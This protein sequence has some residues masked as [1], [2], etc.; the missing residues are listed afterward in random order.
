[1]KRLFIAIE[2]PQQLI[3][4]LEKELEEIKKGLK[5]LSIKWVKP[6]NFHITLAF[7]GYKEEEKIKEISEIVKNCCYFPQ[8]E[9]L[10]KNL[11]VFPTISR[12]RVIWI[13]LEDPTGILK[14]LSSRLRDQLRKAGFFEEEKDFMPHLT[15]GRIKRKLNLKEKTLLEAI[16]KKYENFN[17]GKLKAEKIALFE[18]KLSPSGPTYFKL[19]EFP[20]KDTNS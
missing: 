14:N 9:I 4:D 6:S 16:L 20:L 13:G 7:L 11:G 15:L 1:M 12:A 5:N 2:L 8:F 3:K 10:F 18:S 19:E 17:F